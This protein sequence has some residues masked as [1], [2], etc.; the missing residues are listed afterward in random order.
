VTIVPTTEPTNGGGGS[1]PPLP[2]AFYGEI[3]INGEPAEAGTVV[4]AVVTGG[5]GSMTMDTAGIYGSA[6]FSDKL[7]VQGL[8]AEGAPIAFYA[9]GARAECYDVVT[10]GPWMSTY[11]FESG[12]VTEL[13]LRVENMPADEPPVADFAAN[14]TTGPSPLPVSFIDT[15]TNAPTIWLWDFGDGNSSDQQSP[16]H[17]YM[18][19]G[20]YTVNL[21]VTNAAGSGFEAKEGYIT[22][23]DAGVTPPV[24]DFEV[25][26]TEGIPPLAI[27][28][29]DLS[30]NTPTSWV[31][32]Y[33][34][35]YSSNEQNPVHSYT[36]VGNYTV[37]LTVT[38]EGGSNST[39]KEDLIT[40]YPVTGV[41]T[42]YFLIHS[43]VD[44]AEVLFD[45][46]LKGSTSEGSL[47]VPVNLSLPNYTN[48][49]VAKDGYYPVTANLPA[50]PLKDQTVD[51]NVTLEPVTTGQVYYI[52]AIAMKGGKI[53]PS[54]LVAVN[55][56]QSRMFDILPLSNYALYNI[57][58]DNQSRGPLNNYTF[59]DVVSNH[60]L[61]A[62]FS[63]IG[64]GSGGGGGGGGGGSSS[65]ISVTTSPT[66]L[67]TTVPTSGIMTGE[68]GITTTEGGNIT[69]TVEP[70]E[71]SLTITSEATPPTTV[72]PAQPFWSKF[73]MAWLIPIVIVIV[74]LAALAYY[75][76]RKEQGEGL[77]E[78]K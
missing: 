16:V 11:P 23:T 58:I 21:N 77:F 32:N 18:S 73:P 50:Y 68:S 78:E 8:I 65:S 25:N 49:T 26:I 67:P 62:Y 45:E 44:G 7:I 42:G 43:N 57:L 31:W 71:P 47:L 70:T 53:T 59:T 55:A 33:G 75:N 35:G 64:G 4:S 15:S 29:T 5:G 19:P 6:T 39:T 22:V 76:Y 37:I 10:D 2:H 48:Y 24:A 72:P 66:T 20:E 3:T 38:N 27:G 40:V 51:I 54:G 46:D 63:A 14:R 28:F 12:E 1:V 60:T 41:D 74:L 56:G 36:A 17:T 61:T 30:V 13:N 9:D 34:D 69:L 52:T